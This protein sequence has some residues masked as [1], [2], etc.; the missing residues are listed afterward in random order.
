MDQIVGS[1]LQKSGHR[2]PVFLERPLAFHPFVG[3]IPFRIPLGERRIRPP[4][5]GQPVVTGKD[6][7]NPGDIGLDSTAAYRRHRQFF[8]GNHE[9][10]HFFPT[11]QSLNAARTERLLFSSRIN[12]ASS[13]LVR[14]F[15]KVIG[16]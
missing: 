2:L 8:R 14:A 3:D 11:F 6:W 16:S 7:R 13:F 1:P 15:K 9:D 5:D 12:L 10:I 4:K